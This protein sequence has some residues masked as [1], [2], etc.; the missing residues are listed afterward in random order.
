[1]AVAALAGGD[2][3]PSEPDVEAQPASATQST[4]STQS[5]ASAASQTISAGRRARSERAAGMFAA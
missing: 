2:A 3:V 1:V 4:Q 5:A